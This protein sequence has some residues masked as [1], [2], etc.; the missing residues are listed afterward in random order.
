MI[1]IKK[2]FITMLCVLASGSLYA[3][4][5]IG[6]I[7]LRR[8][9]LLHPAMIQYSPEKKAFKVERD[10]TAK[11]AVKQEAKE[12]EKEIAS[13]NKEMEK[14]KNLIKKA[15]D[16]FNKKRDALQKRYMEKLRKEAGNEGAELAQK[17]IHNLEAS[18]IE[19][20]NN[21][22]LNGYYNQYSI[23]EE[24]LLKLT[25]FG[26][27]EKYTTPSETEKQFMS[28]LSEVKATIKKVAEQR[29]ISVVLNTGYKRAIKE[30]VKYN[31]NAPIFGSHTLGGIFQNDMPEELS[32]D[33]AAVSG[34]YTMLNDSVK[35]W[36]READHVLN[37]INSD[38]IETDIIMG[39]VD[40]T[41]EVLKTLY[42]KYKV[43]P[44]IGNAVIQ[45]AL[46]Y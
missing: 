43:N 39:G 44:A 32:N 13:L 6:K 7:D 40:L 18:K 19:A 29:G 26:F 35:H 28:I 8:V 24:K 46:T 23:A 21:L 42:D 20:E 14:I 45:S 34:F 9:M 30:S 4:T 36:L 27:D 33:E 38:F 31:E 37:R 16:E 15:D 1:R 41:Q 5:Q 2:A 11:K 17:K 12:V 25:Q 3:Q 22:K 10:E